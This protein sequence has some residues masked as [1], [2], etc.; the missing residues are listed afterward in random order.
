MKA[1]YF[2]KQELKKLIILQKNVTTKF[3]NT[4]TIK[5]HFLFWY[6]K[7]QL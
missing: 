5:S 3:K 6:K 1:Y 4:K 2:N 7:R